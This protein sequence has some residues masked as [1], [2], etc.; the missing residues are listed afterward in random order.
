MLVL[1][2]A[3]HDEAVTGPVSALNCAN[4]SEFEG[5]SSWSNIVTLP[6]DRTFEA[7]QESQPEDCGTRACEFEDFEIL[8]PHNW[9]GVLGATLTACQRLVF[10]IAGKADAPLIAVLGGISAG[11]IVADEVADHAEGEIVTKGWWRE[12]AAKEAALDLTKYQIVSMDFVSG[13]GEAPLDLTPAD[14]ADLFAYGLSEL[15]IDR[16]HAFVGA[17]FGGMVALSFARQFPE[18]LD[19]LAL[20]CAAHRPSPLAQAWRSVQQ[21][22]LKFAIEAGRPE[23][24]VRL[25]RALAMTTYRSSGEFNE[26]FSCEA[27]A[28]GGVEAYINARGEAYQSQTT[29]A[30]FLTLSRAIDHHFEVPEDISTPTLV[31]GFDTDQIVLVSDAEDLADRLSGPVELEVFSS[32]YGHDAFLKETALITPPLT[33]FLCKE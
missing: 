30:R 3:F 28:D 21:Q 27:S 32:L 14:Q 8:P 2:E 19:R 24:G 9:R 31:I 4:A 15:G 13:D 23:E 12:L 10:R 22:T 5:G 17:S 7:Q 29:A 11:R 18:K 33:K 25:A 16:L 20:V 1:E 26:R 6:V